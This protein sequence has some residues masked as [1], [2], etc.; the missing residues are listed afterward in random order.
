RP[1]VKVAVVER[2]E[3]GPEKVRQIADLPP[4]E[5]LLAQLAGGLNAPLSRLAGGMNELL[6]RFARSLDA[7]REQKEGAGA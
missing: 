4:R 5:V 3:V 6:A 1:A 2:R 7:L